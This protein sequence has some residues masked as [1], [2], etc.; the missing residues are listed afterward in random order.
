MA[1]VIAPGRR[2]DRSLL[3]PALSSPHPLV[4]LQVFELA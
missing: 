2:W 4:F 3:R 1:G